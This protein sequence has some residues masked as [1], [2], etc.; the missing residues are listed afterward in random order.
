M[1]LISITLWSDSKAWAKMQEGRGEGGLPWESLSLGKL[2]ENM[3]REPM[4]PC[5]H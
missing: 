1:L 5:S 4:V 3:G 2:A